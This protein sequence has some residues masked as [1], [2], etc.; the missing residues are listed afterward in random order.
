M[1]FE[2]VGCGGRIENRRCTK[3][4]KKW[5]LSSYAV[6]KDI[7]LLSQTREERKE[8]LLSKSQKTGTDYA[9][10]AD[11]V[12]GVPL[13]ARNLPNWK[14]KWR[15]LAFIV[16]Y[17]VLGI[18]VYYVWQW[19]A[20]VAQTLILLMA[21]PFIAVLLSSLVNKFFKGEEKEEDV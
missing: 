10:W 1:N 20:W 3:C 13:V 21:L 2:H 18:G 11:S 9:E 12:P 15:V 19:Q 5:G 7:K 4:G 6:A 16:F 14:R 17:S 8:R